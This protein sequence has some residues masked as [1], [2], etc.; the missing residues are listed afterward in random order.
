MP[1]HWWCLLAVCKAALSSSYKLQHCFAAVP[2]IIVSTWQVCGLCQIV[3]SQMVLQHGFRAIPC[4]PSTSSWPVLP[5]R[6]DRALRL[7]QLLLSCCRFF[8]SLRFGGIW[9]FC[10]F[11]LLPPRIRL[12]NSRL[13]A[14]LWPCRKRARWNN[15]SVNPCETF[16]GNEKECVPKFCRQLWDFNSYT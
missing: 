10:L 3:F 11:V 16:V 8:V 12:R 2:P 5:A 15:L 7:T 1:S 4:V 14:W 6:W 9:E 13:M